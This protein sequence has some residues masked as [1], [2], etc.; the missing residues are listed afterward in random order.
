MVLKVLK[1]SAFFFLSFILLFILVFSFQKPKQAKADVGLAVG[2][3]IV[4]GLTA[5]LA[6]AGVKIAGQ[7]VDGSM[8][9]EIIEK[10]ANEFEFDNKKLSDFYNDNNA[11]NFLIGKDGAKKLAVFSTSFSQWANAFAD[12]LVDQYGL[13]PN[14]N[15]PVYSTRLMT[16]ASGEQF[17]VYRFGAGMQSDLS[18]TSQPPSAFPVVANANYTVQLTQDRYIN[19]SIIPYEYYG[20]RFSFEFSLLNAS[21]QIVGSAQ[22]AY[23]VNNGSDYLSIIFLQNVWGLAIGIVPNGA[24]NYADPWYFNEIV[25]SASMTSLDLSDISVDGV[26]TDGY[27]DFE[28]ALEDAQTQAGTG[29]NAKVGTEV[30]VGDVAI[31]KPYTQ[32]AIAR[33][34]L[35]AAGTGVLTGELTGGY[36]NEKEAEEETETE[37]AP[38]EFEIK[39]G[40]VIVNGLEDFF[41]FCIPWDIYAFID[42]FNASPEAPHFDIALS[43]PGV[44][45]DPVPLHLDLS[46]WETAAR[47]FRILIAIGFGLFLAFK[48]RD[49]IRG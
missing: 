43:F 15:T 41:P 30:G 10:L 32:E 21:G 42:K 45:E 18:A 31:E 22:T 36:E 48:T 1:R 5:F 13:N 26:L 33:G 7:N 4:A 8:Y 47:I 34:I 24:G 6:S 23:L 12:W 11:V 25:P 27:E 9:Q 19:I 39:D 28:Q 16:T 29:A 49:L 35:D 38:A 46:E 37:K 3:V 17:S 14:T 44:R 20:N 2:G 40:I